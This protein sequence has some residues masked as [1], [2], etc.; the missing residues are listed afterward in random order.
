MPAAAAGYGLAAALFAGTTWV[1]AAYLGAVAWGVSGTV[2]YT[3]AVTALQRL[4]PADTLGR[5]MGM[6]STTESATETASMPLAGV[7]LDT[8]GI[9]PGAAA[10]AA[11]AV[12]AGVMAGLAGESRARRPA[13]P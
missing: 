11:V 4:A 13:S 1:P 9:R 5:V 2:F 3:V 7:V 12:A 6:V 8:V 10:L